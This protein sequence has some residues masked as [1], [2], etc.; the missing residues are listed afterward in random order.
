M[1]TPRVLVPP[2][3]SGVIPPM[4]T[5]L[6][7]TGEPDLDSLDSLIDHLIGQG[8]T[9]LLVLGSC[10]ENGA[11]TRDERLAVA[12]RAMRR[13][14]GRVHLMIGVPALGTR[15]A[16][17]DARSYSLMGADAVLVP[18]PF[19]FPH[20]SAELADHFRAVAA[21]I[22]DTVVLAYNIPTRVNVNLEPALL[23]ELAA[24]GAIAGTKDSSGNVEAQRMIAEQTAELA[25]FRRYTGSE[26]AIDGL[27]LGGF[28]GAVPGLANAFAPL[29]VELANRAAAG[30]WK[31]A[32][33]VQGRI[34]GLFA[35]YQHPLPGGSFSAAVVGSLKEALVQQG[36][37]AYA[38][39]AHPFAQVD[40]GMR[41]HV[42][43]VLAAAADPQE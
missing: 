10:G 35:L 18:P 21:A 17:A 15:E 23:R 13:V 25:D 43:S 27:L 5:P 20:S 11:L 3:A 22:D 37:I 34:V 26:F 42:R 38:T 2:P 12:D 19:V 14:A 30:D 32:A 36:I 8:I 33:A 6:L 1:T 28:H 7:P 16:V 9:G 29:H 24:E 41:E 31:G 40:D 4:I 39:T